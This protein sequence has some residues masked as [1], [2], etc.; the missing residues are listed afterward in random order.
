MASLSLRGTCALCAMCLSV[1]SFWQDAYVQHA[2]R[3]RAELWSRS[4][5]LLETAGGTNRIKDGLRPLASGPARDEG[6]AELQTKNCRVLL[7][8]TDSAI[9][10]LHK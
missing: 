2:P 1:I 7:S 9:E 6:Q 10:M 3:A 4:F 5:F 8:S